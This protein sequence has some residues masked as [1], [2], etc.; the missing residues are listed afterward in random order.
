MEQIIAQKKT[1][2]TSLKMRLFMIVG[3]SML[4]GGWLVLVLEGVR[5]NR[6]WRELLLSIIMGTSFSIL[7][8]IH[9]RRL[10]RETVGTKTGTNF[11]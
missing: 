3:Q 1:K 2:P 10:L 9:V 11:Q 8:G 5:L 4:A 6:G 7:V